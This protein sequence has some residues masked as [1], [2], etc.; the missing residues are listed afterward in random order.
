MFS[1]TPEAATNNQVYTALAVVIR[2][3]LSKMHRLHT[4]HLYG[5]NAKQVHYLSMEFLVGRS[6]KNNLSQLGIEKIAAEIVEEA[7][8]DIDDIYDI[9]PDAG[10]GNGGLGRLA[11]CYMSALSTMNYHSTGY[12]ILYQFG[13]FRQHIVDG[14]QQEEID[15][16]MMGGEVWLTPNLDERVE[17]RFGGDIEEIWTNNNLLIKYSNYETI[18]AVPYD[19]YV[20]GYMTGTVNKLRLWKAQ[21]IGMDMARFNM[22]DY[23]GVTY[24]EG[25]AGL[26]SKVLYP[27][28]NHLEGKML[29]LRQQYFLCSASLNDIVR[30][31]LSNYGTM[32][33][34][35]EKN[36]IH[37]ND[38][39]PTLAIPELMRIL[40]DEC[41]YDWDTS[42]SIVKK[43]F[44]YTNH[45]VLP[46]ALEQWSIDL[47]KTVLPRIYQIITEIDARLVDELYRHYG[48]DHAKIEYMRIISSGSVK[49]AN[50][51]VYVCHSVNGVSQIHSKIISLQTFSDYYYYTPKKFLNVTN[52]ID[53]R[54]WLLQSATELTDLL[55]SLIGEEF[56][57][58]AKQL[59]KLETYIDD[60]S[61]L[62][63]LMDA[64]NKGKERLVKY[65]NK[66]VTHP[67]NPN[68]IFDLQAKRMHEYKRQHL[69]AMQIV[70]RYLRIK[71]GQG[72]NYLP[73]TYIFGAKA[74][75]GYYYA[76]QMIRFICGLEKLLEN[77]EEI[78]DLLRVV[79]VEDYR[80]TLSELL[81][82]AADVS[83]QISLAGT[84]A[85]GTSN[86]KLMMDGAITLGTLDGANVEIREAVG[87]DNFILFGMNEDEVKQLKWFSK[88]DP[89]KLYDTVPEIKE[90][91]DFIKK[92]FLGEEYD[93]IA[94]LRYHDPYMV[95]VDFLSYVDAQ[96]RIDRLYSD[97]N[98]WAKM[99]LMNTANS[100]R[101]SAD[102]A[103]TEYAKK[104]W[105]IDSVKL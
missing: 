97:K 26:I 95:L 91:L 14:W 1:K 41:G 8:C 76:K 75:P 101:F 44:S 70:Y 100:G 46:E 48:E 30:K 89:S 37:I 94:N 71:S 66:S 58:D 36:A 4:S 56:K 80:V 72:G 15:D 104:I 77:D 34:F 29:R 51:C 90:V 42:M 62:E 53:Y 32:D 55:S 85:S 99:S 59:K 82:P 87:S 25:I 11:A 52:G 20:P 19:M 23:A 65:I 78:R 24:S 74:A 33:N 92:G 57:K 45:T 16:W 54:R 5:N 3:I 6:L 84:E 103:V 73:H 63:S 96:N 43:T 79:F 39:H 69:N 17:V 7:G 102:T 40:M 83:E 93:D 60:T 86:M 105:H 64:K 47:I 38:T 61:A 68:S 49:M 9:E 28:D 81:I 27:N 22:G 18:Y 50:L 12:S 88:Y 67:I 31:H 98:L 10:L 13:I 35:N 2:D 21:S